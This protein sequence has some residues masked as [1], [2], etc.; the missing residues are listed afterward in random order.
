MPRAFALASI[1][2]LLSVITLVIK[3]ALEWRRLAPNIIRHK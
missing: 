3:V 1:L 2:L